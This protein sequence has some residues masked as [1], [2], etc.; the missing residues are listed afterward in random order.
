MV[1]SDEDM[2]ILYI[3]VYNF[4]TDYFQL[5]FLYKSDLRFFTA[6]NQLG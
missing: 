4:K 2:N 6:E 5:W 1:L 3:N